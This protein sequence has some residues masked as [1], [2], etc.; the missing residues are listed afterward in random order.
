[1]HSVTTHRAKMFSPKVK[2]TLRP[3]VS[4]PVHLGVKPPSGAPRPDFCYCQT[5]ASL[6]MW[7]SLSDERAGLSSPAQP[8]PGYSP[9]GLRIIFY[10][11]RSESPP[12][13]G[14]Q[15]PVFIPQEQGGPV[16]LPG[17][18]YLFRRLLRLSGLRLRYSSPPPHGVSSDFSLQCQ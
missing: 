5:V 11:L 13:L 10:C 18:G 7:G 12:N 16:I 15:V 8:F 2:V 9:T 17:I 4:R 14:G 3:T 6:L 1:M